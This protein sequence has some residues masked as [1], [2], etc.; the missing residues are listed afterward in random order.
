MVYRVVHCT[1]DELEKK[2][3]EAAAG[4]LRIRERLLTDPIAYLPPAPG[5][6]ADLDLGP[7]KFA[8]LLEKPVDP[9]AQVEE[10]ARMLRQVIVSLGF[11]DRLPREPGKAP[12]VELATAK[13]SK[14]ERG[15]GTRENEES[16]PIVDP[17]EGVRGDAA[18]PG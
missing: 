13:T 5:E 8:Y 17:S 9:M 2:L 18:R 16:P 11:G 7:T 14:A 1:I 10:S 3:N 12:V 6:I 15:D 4:G